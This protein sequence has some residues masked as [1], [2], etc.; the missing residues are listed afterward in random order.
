MTR[1][2]ESHDQDE[3]ILNSTIKKNSGAHTLVH[4]KIIKSQFNK[5]KVAI[6]KDK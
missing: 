3:S 1:V 2:I 5:N 6:I 4:D